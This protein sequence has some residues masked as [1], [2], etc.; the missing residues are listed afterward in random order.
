MA[1]GGRRRA[2]DAPAEA[3]EASEG[4]LDDVRDRH[5]DRV[6]ACGRAGCLGAE[7]AL[8]AGGWGSGAAGSGGGG[9]GLEQNSA[10]EQTR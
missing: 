8:G 3:R 6:G 7:A 4:L 5:A 1:G 9:G 2:Q 10:S